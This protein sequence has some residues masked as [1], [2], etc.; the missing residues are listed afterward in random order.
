MKNIALLT[1]LSLMTMSSSALAN[2]IALGFE[3]G[4]NFTLNAGDLV[5]DTA[6][7]GINARAGYQFESGP[8]FITPEA[9]FG[10][11]SPGT[12]NAFRILGGFRFGLNTPLA[13]IGFAHLGGLVGDLE[14]FTWDVGG[15]LD[16]DV[17]PIALGVNASY[18]R[19]EDQELTL[20]A[21]GDDSVAF[22][23][24]QVAASVTLVL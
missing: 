14:G 20:E 21:L 8:I 15:G 1:V 16:F 18:N 23:W 5:E 13:P 12:P 11:E 24:V 3:I 9:R 22:E 10:F 2:G 19:A 6:G 7:V 17:G 4:P